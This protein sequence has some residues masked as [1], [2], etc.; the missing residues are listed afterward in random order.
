[1]GAQRTWIDKMVG[2]FAPASGVRRARARLLLDAYDSNERRIRKF[3]GASRTRRTQGW[4]TTSNSLNT[5]LFGALS[6]LRNRSRDLVQNNVWAN[7]AP[8]IISDNVIG[9]GI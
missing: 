4:I 2:Y 8:R 5:E 3:E 1:M 6:T 9:T 7:K